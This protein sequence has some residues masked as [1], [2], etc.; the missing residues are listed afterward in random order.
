MC[1][2]IRRAPRQGRRT[3]SLALTP[4]ATKLEELLANEFAFVELTGDNEYFCTKCGKRSEAKRETFIVQPAP[5]LIFILKRF[6]SG[7]QAI[8][9]GQ[10]IAYPKYLDLGS[11][12]L[13]YTEDAGT[14]GYRLAGVQAHQGNAGGGHYFSYVCLPNGQWWVVNCSET[15][16]THGECTEAAALGEVKDGYVFFYVHCT[17]SDGSG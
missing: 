4:E 13:G 11:T 10:A 16:P 3:L 1:L 2:L 6:R 14:H 12:V 9:V 8:K 17:P 15:G 7:A 5:V